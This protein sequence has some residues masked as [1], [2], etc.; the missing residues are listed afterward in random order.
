MFYFLIRDRTLFTHLSMKFRLRLL[1]LVPLCTLSTE[2]LSTLSKLFDLTR[3]S[4]VIVAFPFPIC[5]TFSALLLS[6]SSQLFVTLLLE[7]INSSLSD[8]SI[9]GESSR[10]SRLLDLLGTGGVVLFSIAIG[11]IG[12]FEPRLIAPGYCGGSPFGFL[13][14]ISQFL[15]GLDDLYILGREVTEAGGP[16]SQS[17][18]PVFP[19][20]SLS[21]PFPLSLLCIRW[22]VGGCLLIVAVAGVEG[23]PTR[24]KK[25]LRSPRMNLSSLSTHAS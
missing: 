18:R 21:D 14:F 11:D 17:R 20:T 24:F 15:D 23:A 7:G 19:F 16:S 5:S 10:P 8:D 4:G 13:G 1:S 12:V 3:L 25:S 9:S 2:H 22:Y 6:K